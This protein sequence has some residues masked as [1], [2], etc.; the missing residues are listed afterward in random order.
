MPILQLA[1]CLAPQV[2][3][4]VPPPSA[5]R[6]SGPTTHVRAGVAASSRGVVGPLTNGGFHNGLFA[7]ET[8]VSPGSP[9]GTIAVVAGEC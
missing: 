1:L 7:W 8:A 5:A 2:P 4:P 3:P 9:A 6:P